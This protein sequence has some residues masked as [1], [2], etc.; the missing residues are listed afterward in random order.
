M[1]RIMGVTQARRNFTKLISEADQRAEPVYITHLN[2]PQAVI[3]GYEAF[4]DLLRRMED[5]EDMVSV[6]RGREELTRPFEE[7][8]A[9]IEQETG[10]FEQIP[11]PAGAVS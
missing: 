10:N 7:F 6:Y 8:W 1:P 11:T 4:E 2:K 9:E 3:I 5:L